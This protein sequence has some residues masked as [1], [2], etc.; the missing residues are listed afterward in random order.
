MN[1]CRKSNNRDEEEIYCFI[2]F[3]SLIALIYND[4]FAFYCE[5]K[6]VQKS[7]KKQSFYS[8]FP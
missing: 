4:I 5:I 1:K 2:I 3:T 8:S 6:V 7:I